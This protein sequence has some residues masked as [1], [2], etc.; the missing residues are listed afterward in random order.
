MLFFSSFLV[1][2]PY[3][4]TCR[5]FKRLTLRT[6]YRKLF[7]ET[8]LLILESNLQLNFDKFDQIHVMSQFYRLKGRRART[9]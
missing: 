8:T 2:L 9:P 7:R 6:N 3:Q 5:N 1:S 4:P